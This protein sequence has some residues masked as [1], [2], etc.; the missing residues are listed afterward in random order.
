MTPLYSEIVKDHAISP[1]NRR[2]MEP[3][4]RSGESRYSRCGDKL[5]LYFRL[6]DQTIVDVS[7]TGSAC[8]PA[9]AA[10]SLTTTLLLGRTVTEARQLSAFELHEALKWVRHLTSTPAPGSGIT[11]DVANAFGVYT[12]DVLFGVRAISSPVPSTPNTD[13]TW[14]MKVVR[15]SVLL[16][17][18]QWKYRT[19]GT[20]ATLEVRSYN[21]AG[22]PGTWVGV[23]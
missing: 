8:G 10:A 16:S 23:S 6:Q 3:F 20:N 15:N 2:E 1:R 21:S 13:Y 7:F 4:D 14:R 5:K 19:D 11:E 9:V 17:D 18:H 12:S 22:V